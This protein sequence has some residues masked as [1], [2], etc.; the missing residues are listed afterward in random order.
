[1]S[2]FLDPYR[3]GQPDPYF[4][5]VSLLLHMDSSPY[6]D[7]SSIPK[8]VTGVGGA[9]IASSQYKFG[10]ASTSFSTS[11]AYLQSAHNAA[12]SIDYGDFTAECWVYAT[13]RAVGGTIFSFGTSG[14]SYQWASGID[15]GLS[16]GGLMLAGLD[17]SRFASSGNN[18]TIPENT[19]THVVFQ[20][21]T[22]VI[23]GWIGGIFSTQAYGYSGDWTDNP[24]FV[25]TIGN[26]V[27]GQFYGYIDELRITKGVARYSGN[28]TPPTQPF[29]NF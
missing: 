14:S 24:S 12:F 21:A 9:A 2:L 16:V 10:N 29:P 1:V 28:F 13:N 26:G 18:P 11:G 22:N 15:T 3:F 4:T 25:L 17:G 27:F 8:T 6:V 7:N 19:W 5:G 20:R 23:Q